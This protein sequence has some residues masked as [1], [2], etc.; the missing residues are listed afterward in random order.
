MNEKEF[1][2]YMEAIHT[3]NTFLPNTVSES[4]YSKFNKELILKKY[5]DLFQ[6][7]LF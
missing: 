5:E 1:L 2:E 7:I 3:S 4:V 6:K